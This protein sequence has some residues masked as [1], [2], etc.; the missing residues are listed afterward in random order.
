VSSFRLILV[1]HGETAWNRER[2][3]QG[4]RDVPL[5][6]DGR[7][8]AE[9][10]ARALARSGAAR[11]YTSPL[12]RARE[13]AAEIAKP[14][15]LGVVADEAFKEISF[16]A[17]E[18]MTLDEVEARFGEL[19]AAWRTEPH[20]VRFPA[21]E[22]LATA[23]ARALGGLAR[24]AA[25]HAGQTVVLVTHG[26]IVRLIVLQALGLGPERLWVVHATPAGISEIEYRPDAATVHRMNTLGHLEAPREP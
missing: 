1:R 15:G 25:A 23:G 8:Q 9:R 6:A 17:W 24:L 4:W 2:R 20:R 14:S 10:T 11:V 19:H 22:D 3:F 7:V 21:G 26:V 18:G 5:S 12:G 13:T 16:G